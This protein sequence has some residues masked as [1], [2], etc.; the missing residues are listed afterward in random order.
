M[1]KSLNKNEKWRKFHEYHC[2]MVFIVSRDDDD[3]LSF[4]Y[5]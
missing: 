3:E 4:H 2:R 5:S 1:E